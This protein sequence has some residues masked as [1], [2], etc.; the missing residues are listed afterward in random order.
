VS[1]SAAQATGD[2][3]PVANWSA[4]PY[5][6]PPAEGA[7]HGSGHARTAE[8][9][10]ALAGAPTALPFISLFP[11]RLVDTRGNAPLTGGFLP[12]AT[13]RSYTLTGVCNVP[14]NAQA[15]SLNVAVVHPTG[16]GFITLYPQG[17]PFPPVSTLNYLGNDVIV[18]AAVVP[19]SGTGGISLALGVSGGDVVLDTNGYYAPAG[20]SSLNALAGDL[21]LVAGTNVTITPGAGSLTIA[22]TGGSGGPPT[23]PAGGTLAGTYPNPTL[24]PNSVGS[25]QIQAGA[26]GAA[27]I[28]AGAVT[29]AKIANVAFG[30]LTGV[31]GFVA[32]AGDT[33]SGTLTLSAGDLVLGTEPSSGAG[34]SIVKGG[35]PFLHDT[36]AGNTFLG[37]GTGHALTLGGLGDSNTGVGW[38]ALNKDTGTANS[39]FGSQ[40]LYNNTTGVNNTAVG[41]NALINNTT[42]QLN[43]GLGAGGGGSLTTGSNNIDI[44]NPGVA[45]ESG[46]IR[47]G[48]P[49]IQQR[50]FLAG[51]RG[52]TTG[53]SDGLPVFVDS[54]GQLGT[55]GGAL[56]NSVNG[57]TGNVTL[58]A[59]T[60]VTITPSGSTLTIAA[61]SSGAPPTGAAGGS[62]TGTYPNPTLAAGSVG[63]SQI[64]SNSVGSSQIQGNA[65]GS[66]QIAAGAVTDAK[67]ASGISYGKLTGVPTSLPPSGAAGGS[68]AGTYPNPTFAAGAVGTVQ[69]ADG[70]VTDA[71]V[72]AGTSLVHTQGVANAFAGASAGLVTTGGSNTAFGASTLS[73]N[74]S[75]IENV[76]VGFSALLGN[77]TGNS[78]LALGPYAGSELTTGSANVDIWNGGV[79]GESGTIRIGTA[80]KQARAFLAG[81][82]GVTTDS[83]DG[84]PVFVDSNGQLGTG[85]GTITATN[86]SG[87]LAGDV[88]GS[89]GAT[90]VS[91]VGA[92]TAASVHSAEL[93]A[94]QATN[95]NTASTIVRRDASGNFAAGTITATLAGAASS[96]SG[97]L[98]GDVTGT[99]SSTVV[100][101]VGGSLASDLHAAEV[102][103]KAIL[104]YGGQ[105]TY[106][107]YGSGLTDSGKRNT[108]VGYQ[109]LF[110]VTPR[111]GDDNTAIGSNALTNGESG[112]GN[113][114]VGASALYNSSGSN[115]TAIGYN[116]HYYFGSNESTA[117]GSEALS[118]GGGDQNTGVGRE[119][120]KNTGAGHNTAVGYRALF[121]NSSGSGNVA[122]GHLS[123][124][125]LTT[126]DNNLCILHPGVA[127]E[128][129]TLRIGTPGVHGATYIAGIRGVT[130]AGGIAV[131]VDANGR[132]GT[133]T[134]SRRFKED[135][136]DIAE[137]SDVLM[138]LRPVSF[139]YKSEIDPERR[140]QFGLIAEEV[141]EVAP[142]LVVYG[143]DGQAQTVRYH[144]L[145]PMLLNEAQKDRQKIRDLEARLERLEALLANGSR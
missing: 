24:A 71:K 23:G 112:S 46:T 43:I 50:A 99:Q 3:S 79:A 95:A 2:E 100:A 88:T 137:Q 131:Y 127:G 40:A 143:D 94:N 75:G 17:G 1:S 121:N 35:Q 34:G 16:P 124:S 11:C 141:G 83:V 116:A 10:E 64:Q 9:R 38:A 122:I 109:A 57:L 86:F 53:A 12:P 104:R 36:G 13:V 119:A 145:V 18:N 77:T 61:T 90:V 6:A 136:R 66:A 132:L 110:P 108:A 25:S 63:F 69:L 105:D 31:P 123:G 101:K 81:V 114:A 14:P 59:G 144:F 33:M 55:A 128:T 22:S 37:L 134:S 29:D 106:V 7:P 142:N 97:S 135:I 4:P 54:N 133:A 41:M 39:A 19:L 98:A 8:G 5:W 92:S 140:A 32:R 130:S 51:V 44:G 129:N 126:G 58:A 62:L 56:T 42:G 76:A 67:V 82:R 72:A 26:V 80:T 47:I 107:G 73:A 91:K 70:A 93:L 68:L 102:T 139:V 111:T 27:Q 20:V 15:I 28:A 96:F 52:V 21:N 85:G 89:Q 78:N 48:N 45:A 138:Q 60:N 125:N 115:S 84:I 74:T 120:L 87:S 117:I 65:V 118:L 113:T 49:G 30:K 103:V